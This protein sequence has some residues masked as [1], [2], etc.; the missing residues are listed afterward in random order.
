M[1]PLEDPAG[2]NRLPGLVEES[3]NAV[4]IIR[5]TRYQN[6]KIIR[7]ADQTDQSEVKQPVCRARKSNSIG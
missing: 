4:R 3:L 7:K 5:L 6:I 1:W 2:H